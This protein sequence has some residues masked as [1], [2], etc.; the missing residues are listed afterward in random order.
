MALNAL[1][2]QTQRKAV[3]TTA[4]T[5]VA[6]RKSAYRQMWEDF[7][8]DGLLAIAEKMA[9]LIDT[10]TLNDLAP[11]ADG[12]MS[13]PQAASLMSEALDSREVIEVLEAR[14]DLR[15][16]AIFTH[17]DTV[18]D[19]EGCADPAHT[20]A[21]LEVPE[22]GHKFCREGSG[23]SKPRL[24][25]GKLR[26]LLGEEDWKKVSDL[27]RVPAH[28]EWHINTEKLLALADNDVV[29][30]DKIQDCLIPGVPKTPRLN[31]R[32]L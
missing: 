17:M 8:I 1:L 2:D 6:S 15:R 27:V 23:Y 24:D 25:E 12:V 31:I 7:D 14:K 22:R 20:N 10:I 19:A 26:L 28:H 29:I 32:E 16:A 5:T 9:T 18:L 3:A 30:L 13:A 21:V 11:T 4:R